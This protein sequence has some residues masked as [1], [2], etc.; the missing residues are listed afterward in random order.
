MQVQWSERPPTT[1]LNQYLEINETIETISTHG[2]SC[3]KVV[4]SYDKAEKLF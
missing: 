4:D 3:C 1:K 2:L